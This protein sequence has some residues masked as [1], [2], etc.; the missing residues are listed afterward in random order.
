MYRLPVPPHLFLWAAHSPPGCP[1]Q[2]PPLLVTLLCP[3]RV[4]GCSRQEPVVE[5]LASGA[6]M[7]VVWKKGLH[8][9]YDPFVLSVQPVTIQGE[10]SGVLRGGEGLSGRS[11]GAPWACLPLLWLEIGWRRESSGSISALQTHTHAS[12]LLYLSLFWLHHP[13]PCPLCYRP[14]PHLILSPA[15]LQKTCVCPA[16][17]LFSSSLAVS[18]PGSLPCPSFLCAHPGRAWTVGSPRRPSHTKGQRI[19]P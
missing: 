9:Y 10:G 19:C 18:S 16:S 12:E 4:Y 15:L 3:T 8:S 2:A 17:S 7:A 13:L 1:S 6:I 14:P 11:H 5:V